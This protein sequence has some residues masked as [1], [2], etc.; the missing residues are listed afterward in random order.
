M[1][2]FLPYFRSKLKFVLTAASA[3]QIANALSE[4]EIV[5]LHKMATTDVQLYQ[6]LKK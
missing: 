5:K 4:K 3:C 1:R 6:S 2:F